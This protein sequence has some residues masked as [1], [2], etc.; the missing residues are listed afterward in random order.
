MAFGGWA[1]NCSIS[2][3]VPMMGS[4]AMARAQSNALMR[5]LLR[6]HVVLPV[7]APFA[8]TLAEQYILCD[9]DFN[10]VIPVTDGF[11]ATR[12]ALTAS[13]AGARFQGR[14]FVVKD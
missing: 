11:S 2:L 10:H 1:R 14:I 9:P 12:E 5:R 3:A 8:V 13:F 6:E 4:L 7:G